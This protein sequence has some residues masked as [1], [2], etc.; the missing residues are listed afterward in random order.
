MDLVKIKRDTELFVNARINLAA[1]I[2]EPDNQSDA[3][4]RAGIF[5]STRLPQGFQ[6]GDSLDDWYK[7]KLTTQQLEFVDK[8]HDGPV[9][10]RG[11]AGTGKTISLVIKALRDAQAMEQEKK[12]AKFGFL[13]HS[14]ASVDMVSAIAENLDQV[15][16]ISGGT[17]NCHIELRTL[18]D[19]AHQYLKFDL[20]DLEPLSLD[21]REG[22][23]LQFELISST[24]TEMKNSPIVVK[25]YEGIS[26]TIKGRWHEASGGNDPRFIAELMNEFASIFDADGVRAG[27]EKGERYAKGSVHRPNWLIEL[28]GE[29][30]RRFF[31]EVHKR[32]RH[33]LSSMNTLSVDQML[34]DFNTFLDSNRWDN[35]KHRLGFD[36]L[37]VDELHLFTSIER[38]ILHKLIKPSEENG[39]PRRP[40]IF[41]AYDMKQSPSDVFIST[42][43]GSTMFSSSTGLQ[44]AEL[45]KLE[46]VFRYTP[47]IAE[48]LSDLDASFPA[49]DIPGDWDAYSGEAQLESG[50]T[51]QLTIYPTERAL[52]E[53]VFEEA[54]RLARTIPGGGRR[55]AVL[56][57]EGEIFD[58]Y[59][60]IAEGRFEGAIFPITGRDSSSELRHAGK[61]FIFSMP[62]YV[63]GLQF[64]T[65]FL[66]HVDAAAAPADSSLGLRRRFISSVYLGASRAE[67]TLKISA[68]TERG[69][70][71]SILDMAVSRGSLVS[72]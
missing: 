67:R 66:I 32:Y 22:R 68:C 41:M 18:Y 23:R 54:K 1:A 4:S 56:C 24:L 46:K 72:V 10:L 5:L 42:E 25:Q 50:N 19:L 51:P 30:E 45:I 21:G 8:P 9:R 70:Q 31:L 29:L 61:R 14:M 3:D 26:E 48:F 2:L 59:L 27:N 62:E 47:E 55:V 15:G 60:P 16:L 34:A 7:S 57:P 52:F 40:A 17:Q 44:G 33:C 39:R 38:Q 37:F 20:A 28:D 6:Q 63:A 64:D 49:I 58:E 36:A 11:A 71:S 12:Q 13:T 35:M 43:S 69:G 53:T 65:V